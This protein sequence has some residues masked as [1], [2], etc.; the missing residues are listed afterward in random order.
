[1]SLTLQ[2]AKH[3][4]VTFEYVGHNIILKSFYYNNVSERKSKNN[5]NNREMI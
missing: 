3:D 4:E 2:L 1:M 5:V